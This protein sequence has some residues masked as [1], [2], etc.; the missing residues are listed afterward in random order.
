MNM[1]CSRWTK[2]SSWGICS[3]SCNDGIQTRT[4]SCKAGMID[5]VGCQGN[6]IET[7]K[8]SNEQNRENTYS[9]WQFISQC[10]VSCGE[11]FRKRF[12]CK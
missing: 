4:R 2:W 8:C 1:D 7:K 6:A 3:S 9:D 11:G 10:S 5:S 12:L